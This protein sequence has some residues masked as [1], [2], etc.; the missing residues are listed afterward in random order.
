MKLPTVSGWDIKKYNDRLSKIKTKR[1]FGARKE[2][3][4]LTLLKSIYFTHV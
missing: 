1:R 3:L 4:E 2:K